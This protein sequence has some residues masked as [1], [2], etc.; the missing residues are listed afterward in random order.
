MLK[1][2]GLIKAVLLCMLY[3]HLILCVCVCVSSCHCGPARAMASAFMKFLFRTQRCTTV[4][5]T[6]PDK[7]SVHSRDQQEADISDPGGIRTHSV[8]RQAA[9]NL[10]IRPPGRLDWHFVGLVN[11]NM[12]VPFHQFA[13]RHVKENL[14]LC[15]HHC[16]NPKSSNLQIPTVIGEKCFE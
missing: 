9:A 11:E 14:N 10:R 3:V 4:G 12:L 16:E 5:R 2:I 6:L 13:W 15:Q 7:W 1:H 8:S